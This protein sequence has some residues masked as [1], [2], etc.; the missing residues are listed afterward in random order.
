MMIWDYLVG[1]GL[2]HKRE[3]KKK[4]RKNDGKTLPPMK[5]EGD[6]RSGGGVGR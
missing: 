3:L 2:L 4:M 5:G 1:R 6:R